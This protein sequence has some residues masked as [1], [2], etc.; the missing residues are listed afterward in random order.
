MGRDT[1][2]RTAPALTLSTV[3][4]SGL[5]KTEPARDSIRALFY[6]LWIHTMNRCLHLFRTHIR[7]FSLS[8]SLGLGLSV[9]SLLLPTPAQAQVV[10]LLPRQFPADV[11][12]ATLVVNSM[13]DITL[14]G[15]AD[16]LSPGARIRSMANLLVLPG[17][18]T[19]Q[20]LLVNYQRDT[21]GQVKEVWILTP[22]EAA[23][24]LSSHP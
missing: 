1:R 17:S 4:G 2:P 14:N 10:N 11:Q 21:N 9:G 23:L 12:R 24:P 22:A 16:R 20:S 19:G 6:S 7:P 3:A 13:P 18:L 8:L 5:A 15:Q